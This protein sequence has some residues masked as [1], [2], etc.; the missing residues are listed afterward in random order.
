MNGKSKIQVKPLK[1]QNKFLTTGYNHNKFQPF[2]SALPKTGIRSLEEEEQRLINARA[3]QAKRAGIDPKDLKQYQ[4]GV[5]KNP[6]PTPFSIGGLS[7]L[8]I[9]GLSKIGDPAHAL[10]ALYK[11]EQQNKAFLFAD[12]EQN[13]RLEKL[14]RK[15]REEMYKEN[16]KHWLSEQLQNGGIDQA[17]Q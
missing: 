7:S 16:Y 1:F 8:G 12:Q 15:K 9:P 10:S 6:D 2:K 5:A 14:Y 3:A 4:T 11:I 17:Q 13:K